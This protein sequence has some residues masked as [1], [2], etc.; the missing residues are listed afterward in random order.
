[1]AKYITTKQQQQRH[2]NHTPSHQTQTEGARPKG[3]AAPEDGDFLQGMDSK[4]S[5]PNNEDLLF[6]APNSKEGRAQQ[7][8]NAGKSNEP[9]K[10]QL[11]SMSRMLR[12]TK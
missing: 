3:A 5:Q 12:R 1:L 11:N 7:R 2:A 8:E 4:Q 6:Q 9:A 10:A